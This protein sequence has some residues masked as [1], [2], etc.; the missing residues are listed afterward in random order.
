MASEQPTSA[1]IRP[2]RP[3]PSNASADSAKQEGTKNKE[4]KAKDPNNVDWVAKG[5]A[6][7]KDAGSR[8]TDLRI[9]KTAIH[10]AQKEETTKKFP[11]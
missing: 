6:K 2:L 10:D 11:D 7:I 9:L 8:V 1:A 5:K 4:K 3:T